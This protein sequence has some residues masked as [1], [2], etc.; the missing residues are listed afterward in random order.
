MEGL[1]LNDLYIVNWH[2]DH[3]HAKYADDYV[4][5]TFTARLSPEQV[6]ELHDEVNKRYGQS[7]V[8]NPTTIF[9]YGQLKSTLDGE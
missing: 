5:W 9:D 1:I 6:E 4:T 2:I 7:L 8:I 3:P